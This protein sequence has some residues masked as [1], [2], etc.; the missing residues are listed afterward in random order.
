MKPRTQLERRVEK[1]ASSLSSITDAQMRW[2]L[3]HVIPHYAIHRTKS[4]ECVCVDCGHR[5]KGKQSRCPHC[6]AI[7]TYKQDSKQRV[8]KERLYYGIVRKCREF[9]VIRIFY[10]EDERRIGGK[11]KTIFAEVLQHWISEDGKDTIRA[12]CIGMYPY[13]RICPY[14]LTSELSIK[15]DCDRYGYRNTY[16]HVIPDAFYPRM[17]CSPLL[18]RN[19]FKNDFHDFCAEDVFTHLLSDNNFETLW[20]LGRLEL[21]EKYLGRDAI[22][23]VEHWKAL[24]RTPPMTSDELTVLLD[25]MDLLEY[26]GKDP[27]RYNYRDMETV[28]REH[29]RLARKQEEILERQRLEEIKRKE[30]EKMAILESKSKYFGITFGNERMVVIVLASLEDYRHEGKLQHHCVY[31][32]AYYGKK[33]SLVLSARM[34]D[35]P[36][37]P[38]ETIEISLKD[39]KI[40]Q[41]F[42]A[43][44]KFTEYH[45]EI[46]DLVS[47]NTKRFLRA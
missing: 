2:A 41:C 23:I 42:G 35:H 20:K 1:L 39:G 17:S 18:K 3:K 9:T 37:K 15:R 16:Y 30:K 38:V 19:G 14:S 27:D 8:F 6:G 21:A 45:Q 47:S 12:L 4:N 25:Y 22:R 34:R 28:Q 31:T 33:D 11:S 36:D 24:L 32:N 29:D 43:C 26:F 44:N 5:W 40:L 13:Y 10:I 46:I 7:L